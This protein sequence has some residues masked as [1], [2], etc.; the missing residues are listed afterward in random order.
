MIAADMGYWK[1]K[2]T[3]VASLDLPIG[4]TLFAALLI[5]CSVLGAI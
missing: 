2:V 1:N 5:F 3:I 4:T